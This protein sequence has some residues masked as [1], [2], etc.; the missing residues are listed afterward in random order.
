MQDFKPNSNRFK[1]EQHKTASTPA[2]TEPKKKIQKVVKNDVTIKKKNPAQVAFDKFVNEDVGNIK[3]YIV[4]DVIIPTIKNTIW[5]AF[6]NSLDMILFGGKGGNRTGAGSS[7]NAPY[8]SYNKMSDNRA[9]SSR[10][11]SNDEN[12]N[13]F[14]FDSIV[15]ATNADAK[16][17]L[18]NL[19]ASL[20]EYKIVSVADLYDL[21]GKSCDYTYQYFGWTNLRKA[22]IIRVRRGYVID[23]PRPMPIER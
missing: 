10:N 6:T 22:Q 18:D 17:V 20:E 2:T 21:V 11:N 4:H 15:F 12:K 9:G 23:L 1:E 7:R 16:S 14:D 13:P 8:V 19:N 5:D 3:T